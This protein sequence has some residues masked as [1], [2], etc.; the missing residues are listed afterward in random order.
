MILV[1]EGVA[2]NVKVEGQ[3]RPVVLVH[4][5]TLD[6]RVWD[7]VV[8]PLVEAGCR[9]IRYDQRG[10]GRSSSP[11]SGY[12]YGDHAA[13]LAEVVTRFD[14]A[15]AHLVGLSKGAGIALE[16][17]LRSPE[18]VR[19]LALVAP[20]VPDFPLS[21]RLMESFRALASAIR[22]QGVQPALR[23]LWLTHPLIASAAAMPGSREQLEAMLNTF[24]AG[25]YLTAERD[26][27]DRT[28]RL[29]DL[30]GEIA[31]PTLV[32]HGDGE[33]PDFAAMADLVVAT[34]PGARL[35]VIAG[36][37]HLVP[38]ERP[39]ALAAALAGFLAQP[40]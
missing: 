9:T 2:L 27:P 16:L 40:A 23:A 28:W 33:I 25:E 4:G 6:L 8:P 22:T 38:L 18:L 31:M 24:P 32:L 19:S 29:T 17:A 34:V 14:A 10:H 35:Q 30:L 39:G 21:D 20:L 1:R 37:G 13:D 5:H 36:S 26:A 7:Q 3:G 11:P 12:R 15:P